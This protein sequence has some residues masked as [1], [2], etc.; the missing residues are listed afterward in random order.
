MAIADV[1]GSLR[2]VETVGESAAA[3]EHDVA[4]RR[5][6]AADR[7]RVQRQQSPE[8]GLADAE[9]LQRRGRDRTA[10]KAP[11]GALLVSGE[12]TLLA[13]EISRDLV[14]DVCVASLTDPKASNKVLEIVE[15][16]GVPAKVFNGLNM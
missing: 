1:D 7:E 15:D 10:R 3:R 13:G 11:A 12:D 16:E 9:A 4:R 2:D 5:A 14:A 8:V 6:Q